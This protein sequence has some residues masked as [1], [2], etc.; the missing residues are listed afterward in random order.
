MDVLEALTGN[1]VNYAVTAIGGV[2]WDVTPKVDRVVRD[3]IAYYRSE[4]HEYYT[5]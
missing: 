1:R 5:P 3:M 2:R 4:F